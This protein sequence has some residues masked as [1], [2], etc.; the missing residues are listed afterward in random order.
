[1]RALGRIEAAAALNPPPLAPGDL[2]H[3]Y[4]AGFS[5]YIKIG[6]STDVAN[7]LLDLRTGIPE[8]LIVYALLPARPPYERELHARFKHLRLT[9]E[10]FRRQSELAAWIKAGCPR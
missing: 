10:W 5:T 3:V 2:G 7:R 4:V 1:M 8:G 6:W 9:G